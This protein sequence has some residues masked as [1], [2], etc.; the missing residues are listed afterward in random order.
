MNPD[1]EEVF[2]LRAGDI[3]L[4][5]KDHGGGYF[6]IGRPNMGYCLKATSS[7]A[8]RFGPRI[9]LVGDAIL[10]TTEV[11]KVWRSCICRSLWEI[12]EIIHGIVPGGD[13]GDLIFDEDRDP[14]FTKFYSARHNC[15]INYHFDDDTLRMRSY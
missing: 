2:K 15:Y 14:Q 3:V 10:D 9:L 7:V 6:L 13:K 12:D 1:R 11:S 4:R 8:S 5:R